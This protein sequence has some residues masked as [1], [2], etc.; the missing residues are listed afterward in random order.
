VLWHERGD[1]AKAQEGLR[2]ATSALVSSP[3]DVERMFWTARFELW[4]GDTLKDPKEKK[5]LGREAWELGDRLATAKPEGAAGPYF[6]A[7][8]IVLYS[9][10]IGI[11]GVLSE[12]LESKF[13]ARLERALALDPRFEHSGPRLAKGRYYF[14]MPW[15]KRDL[16]KSAAW[17]RQA[18]AEDPENLRAMAWL[19]E[20]LW[21][22]GDISGAQVQLARVRDGHGA[23]DPA[24]E[25]RAKA[26]GRH[27]AQE[28]VA[29]GTR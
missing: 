28:M 17:Y 29:H 5:R 6:A 8:G 19:A 1:E 20:T 7:A 25:E 18:L 10:G 27:I 13:K 21:R 14:E 4:V 22:D 16:G 11:L 2:L 26:I 3:E 15:P 9:Q 24:E 23:G 12:G